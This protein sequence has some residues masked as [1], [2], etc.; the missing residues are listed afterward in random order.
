MIVKV[1][2]LSDSA[3][4]RPKPCVLATHIDDVPGPDAFYDVSRYNDLH[5]IGLTCIQLYL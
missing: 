3:I 2:G 5:V 1:D 4:E